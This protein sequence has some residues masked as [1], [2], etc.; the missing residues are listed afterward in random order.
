MHYV[1]VLQS[2]TD[3]GLY[4]GY[5]A[6]LRR[7]MHEHAGGLAEATRHRGPWRLIY[8]EAYVEAEDAL[9]RERFLKS[10]AGRTY[11][12]KQNRRHFAQNPPRVETRAD[13][14]EAG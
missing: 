1:Y 10:G 3:H 8:Y 6:N 5:S 14:A 7:R 11:L 9:G 2:E 4:I 13:R 12:K